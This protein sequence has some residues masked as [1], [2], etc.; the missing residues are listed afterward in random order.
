GARGLVEFGFQFVQLALDLGQLVPLVCLHLMMQRYLTDNER[1]EDEQGRR[2]DQHPNWRIPELEI[3]HQVLFSGNSTDIVD[4]ADESDD[5]VALQQHTAGAEN[6]ELVSFHQYP[7][8]TVAQAPN[9]PT[10]P[11]YSVQAQPG[12]EGGDAH[13]EPDE[14]NLPD[15]HVRK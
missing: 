3:R 9:Q 15:L 10:G 1:T 11:E 13:Q 2:H 6:S 14:G 12:R 4:H 7:M 5:E 8:A